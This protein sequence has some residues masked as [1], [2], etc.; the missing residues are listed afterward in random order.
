MFPL[1]LSTP[2]NSYLISKIDGTPEIKR[3]LEDLGFQQGK[4]IIVI[5]KIK[6]NLILNI[7]ETRIALDSSLANKIKV[8]P[9]N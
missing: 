3:H 4:T 9:A 5:S 1:S 2:G 7:K 8:V 6:G